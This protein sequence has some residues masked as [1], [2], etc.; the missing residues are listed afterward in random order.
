MPW[1]K[2]DDRFHENRKIRRVWRRQPVA[3][4]LHV[5]AIT[6]CA[7]HLTDGHVDVDFVEDRLPVAR[8]RERAVQALVDAELWHEVDGG[9]Q[10]HDFTSFNQTRADAEARRQ[11]KVEAGKKGAES[12]WGDST[13]HDSAISNSDQV[14]MA[15]NGPR[16]VPS[17]PDPNPTENSTVEPPAQ[18]A[19]VSVRELF[20]YWQQQCNH[21]TAKLSPERRRKLEARLKDGYSMIQ[22]RAAID[23]AARSPF[24]NDAGKRFDDIELVCRT[25]SKLEDFIARAVPGVGRVVA[26]TEKQERS[27]R[28]AAAMGRLTNGEVA[29]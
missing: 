24:I 21:P 11:A 14:P 13:C 25:G 12:R 3:I 8:Q 6:Y 22:I 2:L 15:E 7:G 27:A 5:M 1:A 16:P 18:R 17:R 26:L 28:R 9:W 20:T 4:G 10:I 23:G 29:R 19:V